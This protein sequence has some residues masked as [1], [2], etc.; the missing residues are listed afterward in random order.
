[1]RGQIS[2]YALNLFSLEYFIKIISIPS[3][4]PIFNRIFSFFVNLDHLWFYLYHRRRYISFIMRIFQY[5]AI[6]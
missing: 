6:L 4:K 5:V 1:M 2:T 3:I